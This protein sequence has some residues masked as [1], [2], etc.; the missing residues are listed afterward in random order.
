VRNPSVRDRESVRTNRSEFV[1]V[2]APL[3]ENRT[4]RRH[5]APL[6]TSDFRA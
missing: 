3:I 1:V 6:G 4:A 5:A 2:T